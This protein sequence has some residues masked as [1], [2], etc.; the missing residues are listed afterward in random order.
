MF[1]GIASMIVASMT[2]TIFIGMLGATELAAYSFTFPL[3]MGLTS[4]SM[5][6]GNGAA[7]YIARAQGAGDRRRVRQLT[8]HAMLLTVALVSALAIGTW[9]WQLELFELMGAE[10]EILPLV[11]DYV[12]IYI[13]GLIFFTLP[14]VGSTVLRSVGNA[15]IPGYIMISTSALQMLLSPLLIFGLL[16]FPEWGFMGAAWAGVFAGIVRTVGMAWILIG[17]EQLVLFDLD[18]FRGIWRSAK[19]ILYIGLPSML[20]S[21]IGPVS[22]GII[23]W[24]LAEHGSAVVAGFGITSRIEMLLQMVLMSLSSSVGPFVGQNWGGRKTERIYKGLSIAHRFCWVWGAFCFVLVAPFG[25]DL[26][27]LIN[28]D[29]LLVES[30]TWFLWIVPASIGILGVGAVSGSVFVALGKP[31]PGL[32]MSLTRMAIVYIPLAMLFNHWWG[33]IGIF[34]ATAVS[35]VVMGIISYFWSHQVLRKEIVRAG[36]IQQSTIQGVA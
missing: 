5:G 30:A 34:A 29:P 3:I 9:Q 13:I 28:D 22:M 36:L 16:G 12:S 33:Y 27:S 25:S 14:M 19:E 20:S 23:I 32:V 17:H 26:I 6:L 2:D 15:K 31:M 4:V 21:L 11:V 1:L 35:N 10:K 7:S 18:A 24:L 8:T